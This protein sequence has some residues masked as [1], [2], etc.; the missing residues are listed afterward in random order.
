M[1]LNTYMEANIRTIHP[2][3][4]DHIIWLGDFNQHHPL[5][6]EERNHHLY[7]YETAQPL[8]DLMADYSLDQALPKGML[9]LQSA[10]TRNWTC[11]DNVLCTDHTLETFIMCKTNP[12]LRGPKTDHIPIQSVLELTVPRVTKD[13]T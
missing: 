6:K 1:A 11:P 3:V 12:A 10:S 9:I 5:W 4:D 8:L 13:P 7:N 2:M